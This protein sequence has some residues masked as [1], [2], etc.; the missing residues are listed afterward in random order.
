M[1]EKRV[2]LREMT[3]KEYASFIFYSR[4]H[5]A[6]CL[7]KEKG[8]SEEEAYVETEEELNKM[9]PNGKSCASALL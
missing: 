9:L 6:A 5:Q 3:D 2:H 1:T 7:K 4:E 8:I